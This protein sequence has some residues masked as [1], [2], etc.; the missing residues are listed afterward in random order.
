MSPE[1]ARRAVRAAFICDYLADAELRREFDD[2]LQ[3]VENRNSANHDLFYGKDGDLT[4]SD[5][6]WAACPGPGRPVACPGPGRPVAC[7]RSPL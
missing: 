7:Q 3:A 1:A 2:G 6:E 4:G 5:K